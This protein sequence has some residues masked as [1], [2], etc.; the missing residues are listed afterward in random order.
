MHATWTY[1][2]VSEPLITTQKPSLESAWTIWHG[3]ATTNSLRNHSDSFARARV[4]VTPSSAALPKRPLASFKSFS[5]AVSGIWHRATISDT[6]SGLNFFS[7]VPAGLPILGKLE[8]L[9]P[10]TYIR[11]R[12]PAFI[13]PWNKSWNA[14]FHL[15]PTWRIA[16]CKT[17]WNIWQSN[18]HPK[19]KAQKSWHD[20]G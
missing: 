15:Y 11:I 4:I 14:K 9:Q 8:P 18:L 17:M 5:R 12:Y 6:S 7:I 20:M 13:P 3:E 19:S 2:N 1:T 16:T 10:C